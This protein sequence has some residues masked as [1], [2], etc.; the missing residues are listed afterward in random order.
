MKKAEGRRQKAEGRICDFRFLICDCEVKAKPTPIANQKS[1]IKNCLAAFCLLL[2]AFCLPS[3]AQKRPKPALSERDAR[4]AIAAAPGFALRESAVRVREVSAAGS[5]PVSV[6]AEV[7]AGVRLAWV[8]DERAAQDGGI[9]KRKR[10]RAAEFRTGDRSWEEFDLIAPVLGAGSVESARA[11]VEELV[12]EFEARQRASQGQAVEPLTR[13]PLT[14]K[15]LSALGSSVVAELS[16]VATFRLAREGRGRW[17][18][19]E[20]LFGDFTT[21]DL[22]T[23]WRR[24]DA[25]KAERARAEL[26]TVRAALE[27]FRQERGFY[28]VADSEV[29]LMDHL[30]PSYL[31]RVVRLDPWLRPYRY[32]GARD[33][34]TLSSDGADG[35]PGTPDDVTLNR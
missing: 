12:T 22:N 20:L 6:V 34:F 10:W 29:V 30:S 9:F 18:V 4:R 5:S 27:R 1:Q 24:V 19:A 11:A 8:E 32:A 17:R 3:A 25:G 35:R 23:L 2:S 14:V 7:T 13:G 16:V 21:G 33:R 31:G 26:E 15:Q 28:V